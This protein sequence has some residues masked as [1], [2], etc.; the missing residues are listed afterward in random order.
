MDAESYRST[1]V[2]LQDDCGVSDRYD[3]GRQHEPTKRVCGP[4]SYGNGGEQAR[5][6]VTNT[7]RGEIGPR[8]RLGAGW[9]A[10]SRNR[11]SRRQEKT[12]A[13]KNDSEHGFTRA[14]KT[15]AC[16]HATSPRLS[17]LL[18]NGA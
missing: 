8:M 1:P 2:L 13:D 7:F 5:R 18:R 9:D 11:Q 6:D 15:D 3:S 17:V 12:E 14:M 4:I 16:R 10:V